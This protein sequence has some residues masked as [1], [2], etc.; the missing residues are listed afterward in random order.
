MVGQDVLDFSV[1]A[2]S[3]AGL[4]GTGLTQDGGA[5][6]TVTGAQVSATGTAVNAALVSPGQSIVN[7]AAPTDFI[8]LTTGASWMLLRWLRLWQPRLTVLTHSALGATAEA[9][10]LLAYQGLDGNAHI[11][12]L[13]LAGGAGVSSTTTDLVTAS[14][15]VSLVGVSLA[16]LATNTGSVHL[17]S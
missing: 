14:D 12:N 13:H 11:A 8:V 2:W 10:F 16:Q 4:I 5:L 17:I 9:D 15:M 1:H 6:A 7:A 3:T